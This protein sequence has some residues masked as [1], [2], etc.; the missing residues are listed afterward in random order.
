M[1]PDFNSMQSQAIQFAREMQ[2][3]S[4]FSTE[5]DYKNESKVNNYTNRNIK[6]IM[7]ST[8]NSKENDN[9]IMLIFALIIILLQDNADKMLLLAL[10]Y[11]IS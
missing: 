11:I 10:L 5:Y 6:S 9:D 7:S 3:K 8:V 4:I 2:K 1:P